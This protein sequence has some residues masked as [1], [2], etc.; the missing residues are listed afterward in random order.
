MHKIFLVTLYESI[1]QDKKDN[2]PVAKPMYA[3]QINN[4]SFK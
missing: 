4:L 1:N 3:N 2:S